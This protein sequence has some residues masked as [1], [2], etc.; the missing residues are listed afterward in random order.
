MDG[1]ST[2]NKDRA[3]KIQLFN[4]TRIYRLRVWCIYIRYPNDNAQQ[5]I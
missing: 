1:N 2:E 5:T 3:G 4:L